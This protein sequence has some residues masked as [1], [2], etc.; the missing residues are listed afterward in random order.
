[1]IDQSADETHTKNETPTKPARN[2]KKHR[3]HSS[4][5]S[6]VYPHGYYDALAIFLYAANNIAVAVYMLIWDQQSVPNIDS[7]CTL[8]AFIDYSAIASVH[9]S[10]ILQAIEKY[11]KIRK[12]KSLDTQSRKVT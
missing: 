12:I 5:L 7:L 11:F 8:R 9:H 6:H 1:S 4:Y 3:R 10:F 2:V